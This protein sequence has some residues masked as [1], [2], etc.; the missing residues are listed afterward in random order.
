ELQAFHA[1]LLQ[2]A[3][4]DLDP[5]VAAAFAE[6]FAGFAE[7]LDTLS[8]AHQRLAGL[9]EELRAQGQGQPAPAADLDLAERLQA[10]LQLADARSRGP[11][12]W[13]QESPRPQPW[14]GP[15][16]VI[17]RV[18]LNLALNAV[19]AIGRRAR[20]EGPEFRGKL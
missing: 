10:A 15:M 9:V 20:E 17:D 2:L 3:G 14:T 8:A 13:A 1:L 11:L 12:D 16:Q 4:D 18:L 19:Q 5:Q 7:R 6:R